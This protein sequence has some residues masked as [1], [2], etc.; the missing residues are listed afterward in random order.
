MF[1]MSL[2]LAA[3]QCLAQ[4]TLRIG[5]EGEYPPFNEI[6]KSGKVQGFDVDIANALCE[7]MKV[8]CVFVVQAWDG[9][10]PALIS[11]KFDLI[12]SSIAITDKRREAVAFSKP[13]YSETAIFVGPKGGDLKA[14]PE[15]LKGKNVGVQRATTF[16]KLLKEKYPGVAVKV[17][18]AVSDHNL[19]LANGRLD[20]VLA[21]RLVMANWLKSADGKNFEIKG[22]PIIDAKI[23]GQGAGIAARKGDAEL[24]NR[25]NT[26]LDAII[27][28]GKYDAINKK[29]FSF[30]IAP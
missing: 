4:Q 1:G 7:E 22:Q 10:I 6:D 12:I 15:G 25:V 11:N 29:Y 23:L 3:N 27:K 20:A 21:S 26:A 24:L 19:D 30:S 8:K 9:M 2:G 13:Y 17:Y 16:E 14:T 18:G 28:N 5:I